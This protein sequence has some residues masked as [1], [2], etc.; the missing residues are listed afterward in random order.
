MADYYDR[1]KNQWRTLAYRRAISALR[2]QPSKISTRAEAFALPFI[3]ER[4]ADKIAEIVCTNHLRRLDSTSHD[5]T[6]TSL[7]LFLGIYGVGYAQATTWIAQGHRTLPDLQKKASLTRTQQIGLAHYEDFQLRIPRSEVEQHG[8]FV[9]TAVAAI[10]STIQVIAGGSYRRGA[11]DCGDVDFIL[12]APEEMSLGTLRT[13]LIQAIIPKLE[14]AGYIKC[15][16]AA[17][18]PTTGTK[19]HGAAALPYSSSSSSSISGR[20]EGC[21][22]RIDFLLVPAAEMGA[23]LIYFTGNDI[24]NRSMRLLASKRGMRLNQRGLWKD[25]L[26]GPPGRGRQHDTG[27]GGSLIEGRSEKRIFEVLGVP[28]RRPEERIC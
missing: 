27:I 1:T 14:K 15:T 11:T 6:D 17:I 12:T 19:W 21:W 26:R 2:R 18:S 16:L 13:L 5:A 4:L 23:A 22:R 25:V 9:R 7:Q 3:G 8:L 10:N 20:S 28:W 24:F